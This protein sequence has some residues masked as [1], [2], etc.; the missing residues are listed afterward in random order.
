MPS[1]L[2]IY[3]DDNLIKYAKVSKESDDVKIEAYGLKFYQEDI[4][5][6]IEQIIKET[7]SYSGVPISLNLQNVKYTYTNLFSLLNKNDFK[8]AIDTEFDYFCSDTGK[9][10]NALEYRT[11]DVN[12]IKDSDQKRVIYAYTERTNIVE[13]LQLVDK[14]KVSSVAPLGMAIKNLSNFV[15]NSNSIIVN[16]ENKTEI[17]TLINGTI[18]QVDTIDLGMRDIIEKIA[19]KE[20]SYAKAYELCKKTTIY[21]SASKD[22][23]LEENEYL[24]DIVTTLFNII[25]RVKE[26]VD[27]NGI[28]ISNIYLT[29]LGVVIN[30]IDLLFQENFMQTR[31]EIVTPYFAEKTNL[32]INIRDYIEVNSAIALALQGLGLGQK[33]I[34]F[35]KEKKSLADVLKSDISIKSK[36]NSSKANM[37]FTERLRYGVKVDADKLERTLLRILVGLAMLV[38]IYAGYSKML[39]KAISTDIE[40]IN[41]VIADTENKIEVIVND[42]ELINARTDEY[43]D[44][45]TEYEETKESNSELIRSENAI[46]N[47]LHEIMFAIPEEVQILSIENTAGKHIAIQAQ[48]EDYS[49]LGYFKA[50]LSQEGALNNITVS[51]GVN[52]TGFISV[53]IEGD[54]PY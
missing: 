21:T 45:I 54:L 48:S 6:T 44:I 16:I 12:N 52:K 29:G 8:S 1:C 36:K 39:E 27:K 2:G 37:S 7:Y 17:T 34:N 10:K 9:N 35:G 38:I 40:E 18:Y 24:D 22:L 3:I 42:T 20:N 50:K 32:K 15:N 14:Y 11:V 19:Q 53:T 23:Q 28:E 25:Q 47:L 41:Q 43:Q 26:V 31:C 13:T 46:P 30:N 49:Q 4:E 51:S 5:K 33:N